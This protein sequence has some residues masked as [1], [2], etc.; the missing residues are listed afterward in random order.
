M[1]RNWILDTFSHRN[2]ERFICIS[3]HIWRIPSTTIINNSNNNP[4]FLW[5]YFCW[6]LFVFLS[7]FLS[8]INYC[9]LWL[10]HRF[11]ILFNQVISIEFKILD[12]INY[13][14][15]FFKNGTNIILKLKIWS[16]SH[17]FTSYLHFFF[18]FEKFVYIL[19]VLFGN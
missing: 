11:W 15:P 16:T 9:E 12:I 5:Y 2:D 1:Y 6:C 18:H 4:K 10:C 3:F 14:E 8:T 17:Q 13:F 7:R 19:F